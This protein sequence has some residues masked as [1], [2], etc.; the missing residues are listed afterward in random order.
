M[1]TNNSPI[2]YM[3]QHGSI[4]C[5][6][7]SKRGGYLA[8][9]NSAHST[10]LI[11]FVENLPGVIDVYDSEGSMEIVLFHLW[12]NASLSAPDAAKVK[13]IIDALKKRFG[14]EA[15]EDMDQFWSIVERRKNNR[16]SSGEFKNLSG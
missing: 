3:R 8:H 9:T 15:I 1:Q 7:P 10:P 2:V 14:C 4:N 12:D 11:S 16:Q 6:L 13:P 5:V